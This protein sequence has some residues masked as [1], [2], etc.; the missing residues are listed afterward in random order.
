MV[1]ESKML[2]VAKTIVRTNF[3][4]K[5][6][7]VVLIDAG[8]NSL[9]FAE[10]L[11]YETAMGGA[12]P[13]I[14]YGSDQLDLDVYRDINP[15]FLKNKP[16]LGYAHLKVVDAEVSLDDS[17]PF[18][19]KHMPQWKIEIRRKTVK[20]LR[21]I[22]EDLLAKKKLKSA[23]I[24]FPTKDDARAMGIP[25]KKLDHI[26]WDT[27][28]VDF[29]KIAKFNDRMLR[30]MKGARKVRIV[31]EK[32]DLTIGVRGRH[33]ISDCGIV[34]KE[35]MGFMNL[36]AGEIFIAPEETKADGEIYFDLPCMYHYGKQ[37][38]GVWFRMKKGK[39]VE[40]RIEKGK[41]DFDDIM[42]HASGKKTTIAELGIGTNPHAKPT[43]GMIIVDEKIYGT[44]HMA[45]GQNIL[46]GGKNESTIHWDFFKTMGKGS[47]VY[48]D[49]KVAM[50]DG[51]RL[52]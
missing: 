10:R 29:Y 6:K 33:F 31:G 47:R 43:N 12:Q 26:F 1:S 13:L 48:V 51:K 37:V 11:A 21:K 20:P 23:L 19:A 49:G 9:K 28:D 8:P 4:I 17:N 24:G 25:F 52:V 36:P 38:R 35:E 44:V 39:V 45:I 42:R 15:K 22:K 3:N 7:N 46:Y 41:E 14:V 50:K 30:L 27:L 18:I 2:K 5:P 16:R 40:Y 34:D 32:T